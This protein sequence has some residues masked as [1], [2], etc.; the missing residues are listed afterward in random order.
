MV[1]LMYV[2]WMNVRLLSVG[3]MNVLEP[4]YGPGLDLTCPGPTCPDSTHSDPTCLILHVMIL[5]ILILL[6][7]ILLVHILI[8]LILLNLILF[9]LILLV[10]N[11]L[12]EILFSLTLLQEGQSPEAEEDLLLANGSIHEEINQ[13]KAGKHTEKNSFD[14]ISC[15]L[16]C[17]GKT[18]KWIKRTSSYPEEV[19]AHAR[20]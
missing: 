14:K 20:G 13:V 5:L 19:C 4:R 6:I 8:M 2:G 17:K 18:K 15:Y 10:L 11:R 12:V 16:G 7:L 9:V 1:L 3:W